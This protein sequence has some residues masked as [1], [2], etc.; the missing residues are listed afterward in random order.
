MKDITPPSLCF[1]TTTNNS[2]LLLPGYRLQY[3][4]ALEESTPSVRRETERADEQWDM[5]VLLWIL[6]FER[7]LQR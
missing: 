1:L 7:D 3:T 2:F 6:K 4:D 5:I